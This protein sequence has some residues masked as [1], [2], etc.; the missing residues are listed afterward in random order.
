MLHVFHVRFFVEYLDRIEV[1]IVRLLQLVL[2]KLNVDVLFGLCAYDHS[3][4]QG[5]SVLFGV[6]DMLFRYV[7]SA[8]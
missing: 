6:I 5:N 1:A 7:G 8:Y 4:I 2:Q 3:T